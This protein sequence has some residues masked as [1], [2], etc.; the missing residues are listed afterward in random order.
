M[1]HR[2]SLWQACGTKK[3]MT[4]AESAMKMALMKFSQIHKAHTGLPVEVFTATVKQRGKAVRRRPRDGGPA[5]VYA[6]RNDPDKTTG[7]R[8]CRPA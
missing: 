1:D 5:Q 8:P 3:S 6:I 2:L 7:S 4:R